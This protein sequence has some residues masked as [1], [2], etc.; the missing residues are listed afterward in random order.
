[1]FKKFLTAVLCSFM[2]LCTTA[3]ASELKAGDTAYVMFNGT[4]NV[5]ENPVLTG[6][7]VTVV[8]KGVRVTVL[9]SYVI[10]E[11]NRKFHKI[12]LQDGS[13][14]YILAYTSARE[15]VAIL[16]PAEVAE[17][18]LNKQWATSDTDKYQHAIEMTFLSDY[19][20]GGSKTTDGKERNFYAKVPKEW[21]RHDRPDSLPLVGIAIVHIGDEGKYGSVKAS[22]YPGEP[23]IDYHAKRIDELKE[24][25]YAPRNA[26]KSKT[27]A[28]ANTAFYV[29][30]SSEFEVVAYNEDWVAVWSEGGVDES[31]GAIIQCGGGDN[32]A[33]QSWKPGVYFLPRQNCYILDIN[34]QVSTAPEIQ[35]IGNRQGNRSFDD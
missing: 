8:S 34:N 22:F 19:I 10:G 15:T 26:D 24:I 25:G 28:H 14:G 7:T 16:E 23:P 30:T 1:M 3:S 32:S 13:I 4:V 29:G 31:R 20:Y 27:A 21:V 17:E 6:K 33:F 5:T 35:A 12:Q 11:D 9:E 18:E 2:L